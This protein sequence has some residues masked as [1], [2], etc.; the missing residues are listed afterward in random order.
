MTAR[1]I[2]IGR[3]NELVDPH[4]EIWGW[5]VAAYL[6]LGGVVAGLMVLGTLLAGRRSEEPA[7]RPLR[8]LPFLAPVLLSAGM[9]CLLLDLENKA[10]AYRFYLSFEPTSPM[11]WGAWIL[12]LIYPVTVGLGLAGLSDGEAAWL[13]RW[14]ALRV[15]GLGALLVWARGRALGAV[16][17]LRRATIGLGIALGLYT[18]I[19]LG[20]LQ[21]RA[22][23]SSTMLAPLFLVSGLSTGAALLMLLPLGESRR[24]V[25]SRW[26]VW[27][28]SAELALLALFFLD[29]FHA[30]Q[31]GAAQIARFLGGDLTAVFWSFVV[32]A[33]LLM[34]LSFGWL[35]ARRG[36]RPSLAAPLLVLMGGMLLR[37]ILVSAGQATVV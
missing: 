22:L 4:L 20:T 24:H 8:W 28:I 1:E 30:G 21:A 37:W 10:Q 3:H 29:R 7:G 14:G 25:L 35:E 2:V 26:D 19:L 33:G 16:A 5:E 13:R 32:L 6:F 34:P 27:A 15:T 12:V 31:T 36:L 11:S 18:G 17:P 23:W 9:L